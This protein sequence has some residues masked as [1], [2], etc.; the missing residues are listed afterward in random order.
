MKINDKIAQ[1]FKEDPENKKNFFSFE[2]FPARTE[3]GKS[4]FCS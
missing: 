4:L 3:A 1:A 2:Y